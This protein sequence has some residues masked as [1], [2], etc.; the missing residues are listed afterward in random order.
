MEKVLENQKPAQREPRSSHEPPLSA[1]L[2]GKVFDYVEKR[3]NHEHKPIH[4]AVLPTRVQQVQE[5]RYSAPRCV[6]AAVAPQQ[7]SRRNIRLSSYWYSVFG[8]RGCTL[9]V[10]L[11][12]TEQVVFHSKHFAL[13]FSMRLT[14]RNTTNGLPWSATGSSSFV[15]PGESVREQASLC[16]LQRLT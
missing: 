4:T 2:P 13:V 8:S 5:P 7:N 15:A 9:S 14:C 6:C 10:L 12:G 11:S 1:A 3:G 16:P